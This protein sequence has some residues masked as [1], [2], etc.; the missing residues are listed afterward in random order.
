[1][2]LRLAVLSFLVLTV[3]T[4]VNV[5]P[6]LAEGTTTFYLG[7]DGFPQGTLNT[8]VRGG[9]MPNYDPGR[10]ILPGLL[11]ERSDRGLSEGEDTKY[12]HWQVGAGGQHLTGYPTLTMFDSPAGFAPAA[13]GAYDVFLLDCP[14]FGQTCTELN[15]AHV[16]VDGTGDWVE[17]T[18]PFDEIDHRFEQGRYLAVRVVVSDSSDTDVMFGFDRPRYRSRISFGDEPAVIVPPD[19]A[20]S[21]RSS[22]DEDLA[23]SRRLDE[24]ALLRLDQDLG[25]TPSSPAQWLWTMGISTILLLALCLVLM[26]DLR[27]ARAFAGIPVTPSRITGSNRGRRFVGP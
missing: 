9:E 11:L 18:V 15:T 5:P 19:P 21:T 22:V 17:T 6:A 2:R 8:G 26:I 24:T 12:Q 7:S 4:T 16:T 27:R 10:D 14:A 25:S 20:Q 1:M 23:R 13:V 3:S